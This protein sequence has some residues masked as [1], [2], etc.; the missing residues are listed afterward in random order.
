M[1]APLAAAGVFTLFSLIPSSGAQL[2]NITVFVQY[3]TYNH[4]CP[5][6]MF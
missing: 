2:T 4:L 6:N 1:L 5:H 3:R